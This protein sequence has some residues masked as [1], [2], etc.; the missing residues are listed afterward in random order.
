M[1]TIYPDG[2]IRILCAAGRTVIQIYIT[3]TRMCHTADGSTP[4]TRAN[5]HKPKYGYAGAGI[6]QGSLQHMAARKDGQV[7]AEDQPPELGDGL[8]KERLVMSIN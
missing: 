7:P 6:P 5:G 4:S 8:P 1:T 2:N 3:R